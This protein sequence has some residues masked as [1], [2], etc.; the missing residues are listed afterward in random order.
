MRTYHHNT[1]CTEA[2]LTSIADSK[3]L[4]H[5]MRVLHIANALNGDDVF[6]VDADQWR[7]T[8]VHGRVIDLVG[9]WVDMRDDL[10]TKRV[11]LTVC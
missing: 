1:W 2:T 8:G 11:R 7:Q 5:S 9:G 3:S 10:Y 4:L 6:A